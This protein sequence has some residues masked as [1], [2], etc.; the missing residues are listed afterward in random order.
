MDKTEAALK[1]GETVQLTATVAPEDATNKELVWTTSDEAVATVSETGLVTA[2]AAGT[3]TITVTTVDGEFTATCT[4]TVTE[5]E[6]EYILGDVNGD[7][8]V[9][10]GDAVMILRH[11]AELIELTPEQLLPADAN[12]D[13]VVNT[14][15][16]V[17]ILRFAAGIIT[18]F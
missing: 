13:D 12:K 9:N 15:D 17:A 7:G 18:E 10:T 3:A 4:I 8:V 6:P 2:V 1:V 16:A 14:G 5:A 11:V